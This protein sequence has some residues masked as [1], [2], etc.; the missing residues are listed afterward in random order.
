MY[1]IIMPSLLVLCGAL[2]PTSS[3]T[4]P[5]SKHVSLVMRMVRKPAR[6]KPIPVE[7]RSYVCS[8][9]NDEIASLNRRLPRRKSSARENSPYGIKV[10]L[11]V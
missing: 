5:F 10:R 8:H 2:P 6:I 1:V 4:K 9:C 7:F 3:A 11:H